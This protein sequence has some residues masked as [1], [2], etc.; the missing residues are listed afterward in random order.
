MKNQNYK[1]F[2]DGFKN[3][4]PIKLDSS[5]KSSISNIFRAALDVNKELQPGLTDDMILNGKV[6]YNAI[7]LSFAK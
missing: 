2:F 5:T 6:T 3:N 1:F 7:E 4:Q